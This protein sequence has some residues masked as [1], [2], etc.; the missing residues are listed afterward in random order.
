[1]SPKVRKL[2]DEIS[3]LNLMEVS[4]LCKVLKV[5][6]GCVAQPPPP[7]PPHTPVGLWPSFAIVVAT[8][9]IECQVSSLRSDSGLA[10]GLS[11][12]TSS[13]HVDSLCVCVCVCVCL[14]VCLCVYVS[15]C[16]CLG[17]WV[18]ARARACAH[19]AHPC[20]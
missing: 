6:H 17:V 1:V 20:V 4:E 8:D 14:S 19:A 7:P 9:R 3:Q 13:L 12:T 11:D 18:C 5:R 16:L 2:A 15:V 10:C